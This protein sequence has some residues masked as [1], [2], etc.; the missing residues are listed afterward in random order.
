[1]QPLRTETGVDPHETPFVVPRK[2]FVKVY[3]E[4]ETGAR[5]L[6]LHVGAQEIGFDEPELIP[7]AEKLIEQDSFLAGHAT[8]WSLRPLEWPRVKELLEGL[9]DAGILARAPQRNLP[10]RP[11]QKHLDFLAAEDSRPP[12][13]ARFWAPGLL[14]DLTGRELEMGYLESVV[15]VHR[16]AHVALD[17]EGRQVGEVNTFPERLRVKV[18]TEWKTCA[19]AGSRYL[20]E[21]PM[22]MT[23]LRSMLTH[24]K[25]VLRT[26]LACRAELLKRYPQPDGGHF[27]LGDLH[28]LTSGILALPALLMLRHGGAVENG[29]LDPVLSSLFRVVD[30]VRMVVGHMLDL[31]ERPMFHDSLVTAPDVAAAVELFDMYRS[32]HGVCAG[33]QSMIDELLATLMEGKPAESDWECPWTAEIPAALDYALR[34]RQLNAV[35]FTIWVRMGLAFTRIHETLQRAP[36]RGRLARLREAVARDFQ[37]IIP[38][39]NHQVE[40]RDWS[41]GFYREMFNRAQLGI[42]GLDEPKDLAAEL[43]PPRDLL[44][45]R[46]AQALGDLFVSI[47]EP[48]LA[49]ANAPLL[50]EIAGYVLDYLRFERNALRAVVAVQRKVNELLGRPQ[51]GSALTSMQMAIFHLIRKGSPGATPYLLDTLSEALAL[52]ILNQV[53]STTVTYRGVSVGLH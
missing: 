8:G 21:L 47:E 32:T 30:G 44:G 7:W 33:P 40:Q 45:A 38:G 3:G 22:N 41:E 26:T 49:A 36:V 13:E 37:L 42:R 25:P 2:R 34:G 15:P 48:G 11:S 16:L 5:E 27:K 46:A 53:D 39:R 10:A 14:R 51:P 43:L 18:P 1:M 35:I 29:D 17:R 31:Y 19:Y 50:R 4:A 28:F 20:D 52:E 24:W 6:T 12:V 9:I 23:A